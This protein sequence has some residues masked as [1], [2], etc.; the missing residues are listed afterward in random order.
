MCVYAELHIFCSYIPFNSFNKNLKN[1]FYWNS[2]GSRA[3]V[4]LQFW[5][6][7][8]MMFGGGTANLKLKDVILRTHFN[9]QTN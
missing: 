8:G 3:G 2:A 5:S 6:S 1:L 4:L 9:I 7:V